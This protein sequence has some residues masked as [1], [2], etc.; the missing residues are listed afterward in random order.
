MGRNSFLLE[1]APFQKGGNS[2]FDRVASSETVSIPLKY[3]FKITLQPLA[4]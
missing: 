1:Q 2:T 3:S 4:R